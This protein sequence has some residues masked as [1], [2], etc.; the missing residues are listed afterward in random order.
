LTSTS[1]WLRLEANSFCHKR[2]CQGFGYSPVRNSSGF[3]DDAYPQLVNRI[4]SETDADK[5]SALYGALND[6]VLD[7]SFK[8]YIVPVP[9]HAAARKNIRGLRCDPLPMLV[10]GGKDNVSLQVV[11]QPNPSLGSFRDLACVLRFRYL[12]RRDERRATH[13]SF[14]QSRPRAA[15][16][17]GAPVRAFGAAF[18]C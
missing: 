16:Q 9:E 11:P 1:C 6:Y 2:T 5:L 13:G 3:T 7:Q 12:R 8:F 15:C 10:T 4:L 14:N 18:S 17:E